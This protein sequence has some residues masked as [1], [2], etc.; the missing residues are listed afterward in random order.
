MRESRDW[1]GNGIASNFK[2]YQLIQLRG[3]GF[4]DGNHA[5]KLIVRITKERKKK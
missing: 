1:S 5:G 2:M 4:F 3:V